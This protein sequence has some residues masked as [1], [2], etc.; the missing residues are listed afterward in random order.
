MSTLRFLLVIQ[1][2]DELE[3]MPWW[4]NKSG[5]KNIPDCIDIINGVG[6]ISLIKLNALHDNAAAFN[7]TPKNGDMNEDDAN[8]LEEEIDNLELD[9][10]KK[11]N[12]LTLN[13]PVDENIDEGK[14]FPSF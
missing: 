13:L 11:K 2:S 3:K 9:D 14:H 4:R 8:L 7:D 5:Q 6:Y 12:N 10:K 1:F